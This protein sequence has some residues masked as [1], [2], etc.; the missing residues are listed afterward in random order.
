MFCE[1]ARERKD[2]T[3]GERVADLHLLIEVRAAREDMDNCVI[4]LQIFIMI[5]KGE[6]RE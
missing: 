1:D 4:W 6:G 3:G 5:N 2:E